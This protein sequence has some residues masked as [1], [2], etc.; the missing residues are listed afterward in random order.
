MKNRDIF[1]ELMTGVEE[2]RQHREG[3]ITLRTHKLEKSHLP[4]VTGKMIKNL[5]EHLHMS[6]AVFADLLKINLATLRNWEQDRSRPNDQAI[7]LILMIRRFPDTLQRLM[8][9]TKRAS[10]E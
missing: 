8:D 1:N 5:R 7:A 2:M 3:K 9:V 4:K 6:Q 10:G